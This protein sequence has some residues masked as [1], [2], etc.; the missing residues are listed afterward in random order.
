MLADLRQDIG[1]ALRLF[2]R[3]PGFAA[4]AVVTLALGMG[5]TTT[6]FTL[7]NWALLR[8]VPGVPD[9]GNVSVIWVGT[10]PDRNS[11]RPSGLSHLNLTDV[12]TRVKTMTLGAYWSGFPVPA[13]GGGQAARNITTQ[14]VSGAYF[15]VLAVP[16]Q[17]GRPFTAAEDTPPSPLLGAVISD[18]LWR[19]MFGRDPD[20]LRQTIDVGGVRFAVLGVAT[21]GFHGTERLSTTDLWLPGSS[22]PIVRHYAAPRRDARDDSGYYELVARLKPG[23]SWSQGMLEMQSLRAWLRDQ[24]PA[25]NAKFETVDFHLMGPIGPPAFARTLMQKVI[26]PA[27]FGASALVM[28]IAC[29]NV[30]GLLMIKGLGRRQE[31]AVRKALGA[32]RGR[33][34]RQHVAEGILLWIAGGTGAVLLLLLLRR[35]LDVA[36]VMG[37]GVIDIAPP[38]DWR[39]LAFT[40]GTSLLV[41]VAFSILPAI[42]STRGSEADTLR[43]GS[44]AVTG[45]GFVAASLTVFQLGAAMT[46]LVGAFLLV[47]TLRHLATVPLGFDPDGLFV[48]NVRP[49]AVGYGPAQSREYLAEFQRRLRQ[50]P[51]V[52]STAA[53][54]AAPFAW[55]TSTR[56]RRA[57]AAPNARPL[58][59]GSLEL[60]DAGYFATVGIPLVAGRLLTDADVRG[61]QT[62]SGP[63]VVSEGAARRLFGSTDA[64]GREVVFPV[65]GREDK[66]YRIVGVVG[67]ARYRSLLRDPEDMIYEPAETRSTSRDLTLVVRAGESVRLADEA[68]RIATALNPALPIA[69]L[70]SMAD[71]IARVRTEWDSLARLLGVLAVVAAIL[72]CVGLYGVVAHG[73]AQRRREFGIR[74]ALGASRGD[75]WR[76]VLRQAAAIVG[77]GVAVGLIGAYA[78]AQV[79]SSRLVGVTPLDPLLWSAA[80]A[81]LVVVALAASLKP[82]L[83]ASRVEISETLRAL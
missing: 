51:G 73:V 36:A 64:V 59:A 29:A 78:F 57:D 32:G 23:A 8:P 70:R 30:A 79:L 56:V 55:S 65:R 53:A 14:F 80:V 17:V 38:I 68:R 9:P 22:Q 35:S 15:E 45:R 43:A 54:T 50:V 2:R 12:V 69:S 62:D 4:V 1:Y 46:L 71:T 77:G 3:S 33:L 52:R 74:A 81:L 19:S 28:L 66:R 63:V 49:S 34:L 47:A 16:M 67:T 44:Q 31:T 83:T 20:V 7:A 76:L 26:G 13:S 82:A 41:G 58:S 27:A 6:I 37:M 75:M 18:R 5:A 60:F 24:F 40:A 39:V 42:R 48:L 61:G 21:P 10:R 72:A 25:E 11:F